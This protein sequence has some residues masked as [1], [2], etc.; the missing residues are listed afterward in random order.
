MTTQEKQEFINEMIA[1]AINDQKMKTTEGIMSTYSEETQE[2]INELIESSYAVED[3][4]DFIKAFD[5]ETFRK[6]YEQYVELGEAYGYTAVDEFIQEFSI[7]ELDNFSESYHGEYLSFKQFA[8]DQFDELYLHQIPEN[9][10]YY[11]DYDKWA[12]DLSYDYLM[13][14]S[15]HIFN[16]NF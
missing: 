14:D 13:T 6:Y 4:I 12:Q 5:E 10:Q 15:G 3:M 8:T 1:D 9:L 11:I 2:L 16:R 7:D